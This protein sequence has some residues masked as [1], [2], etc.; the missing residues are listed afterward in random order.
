MVEINIEN[1]VITGGSEQRIRYIGYR[2][3]FC[4]WPPIRAPRVAL[5]II[6]WRRD[7]RGGRARREII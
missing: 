1:S 2:P 7:A 5:L 4:T 3:I 6:R